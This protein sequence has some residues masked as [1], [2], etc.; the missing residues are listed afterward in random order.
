MDAIELP[1]RERD[2]FVAQ[3]TADNPELRTRID[4]LL[5]AHDDASS[6]LGEA[7]P[8]VP[9][10]ADE[11]QPGATIHAYK[12]VEEIGIGG[13]GNVWLA[14]QERPL[15]RLVALKVLK[16]GMDSREVVSRFEAERQALALMDHSS[17]A[18]VFDA[19]TTVLGRPFFAMEF[20][21]GLPIT[22]HCAEEK[23]GTRARVL[24]AVQICEGLKHAHQK[25]VI[26]R[27]IKPSNVLV[28]QQDGRS[29]AKIIDFGI[30]KAVG[31]RLSQATIHTRVDQ[32]IGT[33]GYMSPEQ[34]GESA[35]IDTRSDVYSVGALLYELLTD[36]PPLDLTTSNLLAVQEKI[37]NEEPVRPSTRISTKALAEPDSASLPM[38]EVRGDLDW[39]VMRCLEKDRDRRYDSIGFL[40]ADLQ[41]Y[42]DGEVVEA[43]P[44]TIRYRAGKFVRRNWPALLAVGAV[45]AILI[46]GTLISANQAHIAKLAKD[47]AEQA[48][49]QTREEARLA[50]V[51]RI[52]AEEA[53]AV[54]KEELVRATAVADFLESLLQS[55][56]PAMAAGRDTAIVRE[57]LQKAADGVEEASQGIPRVEVQ[58]RSIVGTAHWSIGEFEEARVQLKRA[59]ELSQEFYGEKDMHSLRLAMTLGP[60]IAE[61][62]DYESAKGLMTWTY[63]ALK[64]ALGPDHERTRLAL[65]NLAS[66]L[67]NIASTEELEPILRDLE[68]ATTLDSG[69]DHEDSLRVRNNLAFLL[70]SIGQEQEAKELFISIAAT[71]RETIGLEH[72]RTMATMNNLAGVHQKLNEF[73]EAEA[74]FRELLEAK[75]R[76]LPEGHP[77]LIIGLNNLAHFLDDHG[78]RE[79]SAELR[80][81]A[82]DTSLKHHGLES[83]YTLT[84]LLGEGMARLQNKEF[85]LAEGAFQPVV[86]HGAT[87]FG[88]NSSALI[89]AASNLAEV[90]VE[91]GR[92]DEACDL[93]APF[94]EHIPT[95]FPESSGARRVYPARYGLMLHAAGR[96]EEARPYLD[97]ALK[98]LATEAEHAKWFERVER[99]L[100]D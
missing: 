35:D 11:L 23:L 42:L 57:V 50:E 81:L 43:G 79:E 70:A 25:G 77:S 21:N 93:M 53:E 31:G 29:L 7:P 89:T 17:I 51:A 56:D 90:F 80:R 30:A 54:T 20:V 32:M 41:R 88:A 6:A 60:T 68:R 38:R 99:A 97:R 74:I 67:T 85:E 87:V 46:A 1:P 76:I 14:E 27:D 65:A 13:F 84:L 58:L 71:Q 9:T 18:K 92:A 10:Q 95:A 15:K 69:P 39:I 72:P 78:D 16:A 61:G 86:E 91:T 45:F 94:I 55:I 22:E 48:E 36:E 12:L 33:P 63:L 4:A 73:S 64:E 59:F 2:D 96:T 49:A 34:L 40:A 52:R 75:T 3:A 44:P 24:L 19:G 37:A 62:G 100:L 28:L 82:I 83:R 8:P 98:E 47:Q 26:H 66:V 5:R